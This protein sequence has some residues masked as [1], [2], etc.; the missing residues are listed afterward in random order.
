M[1]PRFTPALAVLDHNAAAIKEW[2]RI[3]VKILYFK[4]FRVRACRRMGRKRC[5]D[6]A[7]RPAANDRRNRAGGA[8][9]SADPD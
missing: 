4:V 6:A 1:N 5:L 9:Q 3:M 8:A 2:V 7:P